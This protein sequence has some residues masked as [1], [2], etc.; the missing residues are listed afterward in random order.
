MQ[1]DLRMGDCTDSSPF[2]FYSL[3]SL[4]FHLFMERGYVWPQCSDL[5]CILPIYL[6]LR[7]QKQFYK[8]IVRKNKER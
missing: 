5:G 4:C 7:I 6:Y 3:H 2:A 8:V 1:G